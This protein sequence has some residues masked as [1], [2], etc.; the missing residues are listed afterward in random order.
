MFDLGEEKGT[1]FI[2]MEYVAGQDLRGLIRQTG[3]LTIG[4]AIAIAKQIS[5]GLAEAHRLESSTGTSNP[6]TSSSIRMATPGS[7]ISGSPDRF[8]PRA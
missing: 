8:T 3:Q 4:K 1:Y 7:W 2:T 5:E 6:P